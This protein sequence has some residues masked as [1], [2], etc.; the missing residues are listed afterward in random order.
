MTDQRCAEALAGNYAR[1]SLFDS[2]RSK[3][4]LYAAISGDDKAAEVVSAEIGDCPTCLRG[5]IIFLIN[6]LG[7]SL[8]HRAGGNRELTAALIAKV[9]AQALDDTR[10]TR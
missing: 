2:E 5:V 9:L 8:V 3:R 7:A 10:D 1:A 6:A 4:L